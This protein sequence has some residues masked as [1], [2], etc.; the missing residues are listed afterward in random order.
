[1][2]VVFVD[3]VGHTAHSA[4]ADPEDVRAKLAPY[5]ARAR[6]ELERFGGTVEKFIGDAVMAVFGAPVSREDDAERAVRAAL[7]VRDAMVEAGLEVRVAVNTGE[8]LVALDARAAEGEALVA[9]DVVNT[10]SRMQSAAPVNGVLVGAAT[11]RATDRTIAY[12]DA[13]PVVAKGKAEPLP[14]WHALGPRARLG[15]DVG[16]HGGAALAGRDVELRSLRDAF[17]RAR[18]ER[19]TQL[20]TLVGA[21]GMGKSRLVWELLR[22]MHS[23]PD[24]VY[25]RQG[26]AL[27]YG[28]GPFGAVA[29][30]L[31]AHVGVLESDSD[32]VLE[33]KVTAAVEELFADARDREWLAGRLRPLVGL[34]GGGSRGRE[35]SFAAWQRLIEAIADRNPLILVLEDLHWA[36]DGTLDFVEH[37][38]DWTNDV[39]L[40]VLCTS[41][42]ELLERRPAWGGGRLNSHTIALS[43]LSDDDTAQLLGDL[44]GSPALDAEVRAR[45][46]QQTGGNPLYAEEYA[47]MLN[48]AVGAELPDSVQGIIAARLDLLDPP[49]KQLLQDASVLGKIFWR[50]GVEALGARDPDDRLQRLVRKEFIRRERNSSMA[51]DPEFA[52]RHALVRDVAYAQLPRA[53]RAEKHRLAAVWIADSASRPDL[54]AHHYTEALELTR[55]AG[56]DTT[57]LEQPARAALRAAGDRARSLGAYHDATALYRRALALQPDDAERRSLLGAVVGTASASLDPD[58]AG[59]ADDALAACEAAGDYSGAADAETALS[60]IAWYAG[61]GDVSHEPRRA[62]GRVRRAE[63]IG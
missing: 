36:D 52:F 55:A 32:A 26:R 19:A 23:E 16:Q 7:A 48:A 13:A 59:W 18:H 8:A 3:L 24:L 51:G 11:H 4:S 17:Q 29:E 33:A 41:R 56:A 57:A 39:P 50:G 60:M 58:A 44:L 61:D 20:V 31:R 12:A 5:H 62:F 42:P 22:H 6:D 25:W 38:V 63:R 28:G 14:V 47:R 21:P 46:L 37:L 35:E 30:A 43:P 10:A 34:E 27:A 49:E 45:L 2:S 1:M 15:V 53:T 40:L 9:G 54:V